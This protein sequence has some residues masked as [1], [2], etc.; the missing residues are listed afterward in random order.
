V[1]DRNL[2]KNI[3]LADTDAV[4]SGVRRLPI[5]NWSYRDEPATVRHLGPM[6]QDFHAVF[7]LGDDD[8]SYSPV[9]GHGV[10]L[11]AIQALDRRVQEQRAEIESL[12]RANQSLRDR[13]RALEQRGRA[14][15]LPGA[16]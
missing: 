11:A 4:L 14:T 6:A 3:A 9:D 8:R 7:G 12:R 15:A 16:R 1:S 10:V 2:K 5:A 13:L